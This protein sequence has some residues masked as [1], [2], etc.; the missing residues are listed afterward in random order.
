MHRRS[1]LRYEAHLTPHCANICRLGTLQS[2][3]SSSVLHHLNVYLQLSQC[4]AVTAD[5]HIQVFYRL[6][7]NLTYSSLVVQVSGLSCVMNCRSCRGSQRHRRLQ[8]TCGSLSAEWCCAC[9]KLRGPSTWMPNLQTMSVTAWL[10]CLL[11]ALMTTK[12]QHPSTQSC[13]RK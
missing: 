13:I 7:Q 5:I 8:S 12:A 11:L 2:I 3:H 10:T 6:M 1:F 9:A 4:R